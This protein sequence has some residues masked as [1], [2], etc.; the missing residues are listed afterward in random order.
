MLYLVADSQSVAVALSFFLFLP[1]LPAP[2]TNG[3]I[4]S[5]P[6]Q[7]LTAASIANRYGDEGGRPPIVSTLD[8]PSV[9]TCTY[10]YCCM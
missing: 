3:F 9:H 7:L 4:Q 10:Y 6:W 1:P 5:P 2:P 8:H